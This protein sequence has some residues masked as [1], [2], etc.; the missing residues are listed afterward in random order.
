LASTGLAVIFAFAA[1]SATPAAAQDAPPVA[2]TQPPPAAEEPAPDEE[3]IVTGT[4]IQRPDYQSAN[5]VVS[6]SGEQLQYSG[7]TNVTDFLTDVPAV[8]GSSTTATT[9]GDQG[10]I[11]STGLNLLNLRNLG[12]QRTLVLQNGRRHVPAVPA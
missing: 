6:M 1:L 4:R 10:F 9:S 7:V 11:G 3:I 5:P 2:T 8:V 12:T